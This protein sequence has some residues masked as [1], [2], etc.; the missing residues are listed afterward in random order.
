VYI[1]CYHAFLDRKDS[2]SFSPAKLKSHLLALKGA[3]YKFISYEDYR[4]N[5]F[6][7][8]RNILIT[9]D[10][11]NRSVYR[12]YFEIMKPLGIKPLLAIYPAAT[13]RTSYALT[14]KQLEELKNEGC[15]IAAHGFNHRFL[16]S[17]QFNASEYLFKREIHLSKKI[18]EERLKI[19][20]EAF[21]YPYGAYCPEAFREIR[22]AGYKYA[23]TVKPGKAGYIDENPL[24][25]KRFM[26]TKQN[27]KMFI[28]S[29]EKAHE[30]AEII[31]VASRKHIKIKGTETRSI[32]IAAKTPEK[33][34]KEAPK[35]RTDIL[36][37]FSRKEIKNKYMKINSIIFLNSEITE[38]NKS[39]FES[40]GLYE[41]NDDIIRPFAGKGKPEA[42]NGT[43]HNI[44]ADTTAKQSLIKKYSGLCRQFTVLQ[45]FYAHKT[46]TLL[47]KIFKRNASSKKKTE[48]SQE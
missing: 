47:D 8:S 45:N 39:D 41:N 44:K 46:T 9:V 16:N 10:D 19:K 25:I 33:S 1:L 34:V 5:R 28:A 42:V 30:D 11:G 29:L 18:L 27:E 35:I 23:F 40:P 43:S 32:K 22:K 17:K 38:K 15:T 20:I 7:G 24:L 48:R 14:W 4:K 13:G 37:K 26:M 2:I 36:K 3:G 6:K 21:V 31:S 12:T